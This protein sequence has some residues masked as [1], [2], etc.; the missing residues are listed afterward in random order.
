MSAPPDVSQPH[1]PRATVEIFNTATKNDIWGR[2]LYGDGDCSAII[3]VSDAVGPGEYKR[4]SRYLTIHP[5]A[6]LM[7]DRLLIAFIGR[8]NDI[9]SHL[10]SN[11]VKGPE[12][13]VMETVGNAV[14]LANTAASSG[15]IFLI[16]GLYRVVLAPIH[17]DRERDYCE[18]KG[19]INGEA[20]QIP[21]DTQT[22]IEFIFNNGGE[23]YIWF[24][25]DVG[26]NI[27]ISLDIV[28][29]DPIN[30]K[31]IEFSIYA[32]QQRRRLVK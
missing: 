23:R 17:S 16:D 26:R 9:N 11:M 3:R 15:S 27:L 5:R 22:P 30:A 19:F 2:L 8:K 1:A 28:N 14:D 4:V 18:A 10:I 31:I 25:G 21:H 24:K 6:D 32:I 20:G 29:D 12:H 7:D 13:R